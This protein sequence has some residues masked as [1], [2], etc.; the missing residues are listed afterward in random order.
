MSWQPNPSAAAPTEVTVRFEALAGR[1]TRVELTH[2]G[3][4][5]LGAI[6]ATQRD[7]YNTGW[8]GVLAAYV[9]VLVG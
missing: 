6:A 3:W 2:V 8:D 4:E 5:R 7:S 9:G 1:L